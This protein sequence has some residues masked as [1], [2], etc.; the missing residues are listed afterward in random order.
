VCI[1]T[2]PSLWDRLARLLHREHHAILLGHRDLMTLPLDERVERG[3]SLARLVYGG[4]VSG[5]ITLRCADNLAKYRIGD[6]LRLGNGERAEG[7]RG[8]GV[9]YES[10][11]DAKG[12]LIVSRDPPNSRSWQ[13]A[14]H[15][16]SAP[17]G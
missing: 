15:H 14:H 1:V 6:A 5:R 10:F 2:A 8:L 11:D 4:E 12:T 13:S 3:D 7:A 17:K 9:I 16:D